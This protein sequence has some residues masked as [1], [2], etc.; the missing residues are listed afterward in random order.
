[1]VCGWSS[2]RFPPGRDERIHSRKLKW[3]PILGGSQPINTYERSYKHTLYRAY[4]GKSHRRGTL[5]GDGGG[6]SNYP[7]K[8][9]VVYR[10]F[11]FSK[12]CFTGSVLVFGG[13][14][15]DMHV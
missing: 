1:M 3:N 11:S 4:I 14:Y 12:G 8:Y 7:L 10:C 13:V 15:T 2:F 9:L 6:T 5:V